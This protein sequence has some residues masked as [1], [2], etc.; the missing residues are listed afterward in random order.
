MEY[1]GLEGTIKVLALQGHPNN[2]TPYLGELWQPWGWD[3]PALA[4]L[5]GL[6]AL[7]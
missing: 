4:L 1:S 7:P 3:H 6:Q 2:P 5:C